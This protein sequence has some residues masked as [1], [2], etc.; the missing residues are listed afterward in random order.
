MAAAM[1]NF[2]LGLLTV[3]QKRR[4]HRRLWG[5]SRW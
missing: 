3:E 2:E 5:D 1:A 4:Y